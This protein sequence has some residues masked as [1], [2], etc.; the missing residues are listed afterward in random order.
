MPRVYHIYAK[1]RWKEDIAV[2]RRYLTPWN[3]NV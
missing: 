3:K 2:E 1:R